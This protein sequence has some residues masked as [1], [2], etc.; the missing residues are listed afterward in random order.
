MSSLPNLISN[1]CISISENTHLLPYYMGTRKN[2]KIQHYRKQIEYQP[3][4]DSMG[5]IKYLVSEIKNQQ[6]YD[7]QP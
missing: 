7:K 6:A 4:E 1:I 3:S 5:K 2:I